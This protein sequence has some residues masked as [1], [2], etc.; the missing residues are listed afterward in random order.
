ML[1]IT[2]V[3]TGSRVQGHPGY[4]TCLEASLS[5]N[6]SSTNPFEV[7]NLRRRLI[8]YMVMQLQDCSAEVLRRRTKRN[9]GCYLCNWACEFE[10][11]L[12]HKVPGHPVPTTV[13]PCLCCIKWNLTCIS[14]KMNSYCRTHH[15][16][17]ANEINTTTIHIWTEF[18]KD[19]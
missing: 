6:L 11:I 7:I 13:K 4:L 1:L 2:A 17:I 18:R 16:R 5:K 10:A 8:Q 14:C 3:G 12:V 15:K 9:L 19:T